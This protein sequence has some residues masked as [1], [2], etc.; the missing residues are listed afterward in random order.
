[1]NMSFAAIGGSA[2]LAVALGIG[3]GPSSGVQQVPAGEPVETP[4]GQ[5]I[6]QVHRGPGDVYPKCLT[7][8]SEIE[9]A[10]EIMGFDL[11]CTFCH[12]GDPDALD[13]ET[14]HVLPTLPVIMDKTVPPLDY[15]LPYQRF[16]NPTNL[17]VIG[18]T[19]GICH[20]EQHDNIFKSM[21]ATAAGHYA[22]GL[23]QNGV[24]DSK[25][26]IYGTFEVED[27]DGFVPT[28]RGAVQRLE[29]LIEYDPSGDP[30]SNA[31]HFA[32]VPAQAC[33][34]CH[35]WSRGKGYRGAENADGV[36]RADGCAACHMLYDNDGLSHSADLNIDHAEKGHPRIHKITRQIDTEQCLHCHHRGARIGL[37]FTGRSQMPPRLPSGPDVAGTT[38]ER[39]NGNYHYNVFDVNPDDAHHRAGLHCIDCHTARGVMGD[40]NIYGHMDQATKIECETCHGRPDELPTLQDHDNIQL[41]NAEFV[42]D[43]VQVTS[44]VDGAVHIVP[45]VKNVVD[46]ASDRYNPN[47]VCAM[48]GDHIK[49]EGGVECYA[50]H[51]AWTPNC[52]GCHFERDERLTGVNLVTRMEE[53]GKVSTNNKVFETMRPFFIGPNSEGRVAPYLVACQPIADVTAP[54]GTKIL[55]MQMPTTTKGLSGLALNPVQPHTVQGAGNVRTCAECHRSPASLGMGTGNYSLARDYAYVAAPGG[56]RVYDRNTDP[57]MPSLVT[58]LNIAD[59]R[60]IVSRPDVVEGSADALYVAAGA[61]GLIGFDLESGLNSQPQ[62]L[63]SGIN[64]IDVDRVADYFYVVDEGVGVHVYDSREGASVLSDR[65]RRPVP[66]GMATPRHVAT[67]DIPDARRVVVWGIHLFVPA[68]EGGL[69]VVNIADQQSPVV[70]GAVTGINAADVR[71]YTHYQQGAAFAVRAY[72]ADPGAGVHVIDLLPD[73]GSPMLLATLPLQGAAGLDTYTAWVNGDSA[74]PSFEH[75]YLHVAAGAAGLHIFDIT[76]PD[77]I[78]EVAA[79]T[80]LGGSVVAVDVASQMSPP[81]VEDYAVLANTTE[82]LQVVD[83]TFPPNPLHVDTLAA[84]GASGVYVEVQQLDRFLN[85]QG[86]QLKE[87]SHPFV[88]SFSRADVVRILSAS[89]TDCGPEPTPDFNGDGVVDIRDIGE[90]V[91]LLRQ[92]SPRADLNGDG[93]VDAGDIHVMVEAM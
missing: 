4:D 66:I 73:I 40:G 86:R 90:F 93:V 53:V 82:G 42:G 20:P 17:R 36:Y 64:A 72:V 52:F 23:Y 71:V 67:I 28:E 50:C 30:Q 54:D 63:I 77:N 33:A 69:H 55:D 43:N 21:M 75:D 45:L 92:N 89:I 10:T 26:P 88:Q 59:P 35:L 76:E 56:V 83:V 31:T 32:Q 7:C 15:D 12:G 24:Q 68:G 27:T 65:V 91:D 9:N 29:D 48:N 44:K 37:S 41:L 14:A 80:D 84:P 47:A 1:M 8:H 6:K 78:F 34:R 39:F 60:G 13:I 38:D 18:D 51:S 25:T 3:M 22:G 61:Q 11:D 46:P 81:G 5:L 49:P 85:E 2:L 70:V 62:T 79:V 19:C 87:N 57:L 74:T 16:V 58:T